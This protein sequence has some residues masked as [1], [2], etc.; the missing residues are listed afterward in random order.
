MRREKGSSGHADL[1]DA[2]RVCLARCKLKAATLNG[3]AAR[4]WA[5]VK[6]VWKL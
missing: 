5:E 2:A 4:E 6:Y 1:D 3:R